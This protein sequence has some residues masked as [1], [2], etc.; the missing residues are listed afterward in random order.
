MDPSFDMSGFDALLNLTQDDNNCANP[1]EDFSSNAF[2]NGAT[3]PFPDVTDSDFDFGQPAAGD[4]QWPGTFDGFDGFN[5]GPQS[6][7]HDLPVSQT[8]LSKPP[9]PCDYCSARGLECFFVGH[10]E[11]GCSSCQ[12]LFRDCTFVS[13]KPKPG[14]LDTLHTVTEDVVMETGQVTGT[15]PLW[16]NG[17]VESYGTAEPE[18]AS[19][20]F[21]RATTLVLKRWLETHADNPYPTDVE[22]ER[23]KEETG[24]SH[25]QISTWLGKLTSASPLGSRTLRIL[26]QRYLGCSKASR[27]HT[28]G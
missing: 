22:K 9:V 7:T 2:S 13:H 5:V 10:D 11:T 4:E 14:W 6:T 17:A 28:D 23:L 3:N 24:L 27:N 15:K 16:S 20:R 8:A 21:P 25:S 26:I 19:T 12:A 1:L 18:R